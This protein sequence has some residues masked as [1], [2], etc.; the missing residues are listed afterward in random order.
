MQSDNDES[1]IENL[2]EEYVRTIETQPN[3]EHEYLTER[4]TAIRRVWDTFQESATSVTQLYKDRLSTD[5]AGALW[6]PFQ[7]AAGTITT[8]YKDA[9]DGFRRTGDSAIQCGYQRRTRELA[10]WA[11]SK[12]RRYIRRED[13][14]SYLAGKPP[15]PIH[16]S[17]RSSPK[18]ESQHVVQFGTTPFI[19]SNLHHNHHPNSHID[20]GLH[21]FKEALARRQR[22]P[23]LYAFVTGEIARHCKRPASPLDVN[24][25]VQNICSKRQRFM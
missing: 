14:L 10:D 18:P 19:T 25:E 7:T 22:T 3:Y 15:P 20:N 21:T 24:M 9:C 16:V 4:D 13:L 23:E 8:L 1:W 12:K 6:L 17:K 11:R 5:D 2:E